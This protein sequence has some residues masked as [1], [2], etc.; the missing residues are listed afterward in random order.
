M[1]LEH[2]EC[3]VFLISEIT[4]DVPARGHGYAMSHAHVILHPTPFS[5][6]GNRAPWS[7]ITSK[8]RLK[9]APTQESFTTC[10][11]SSLGF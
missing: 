5:R 2:E 9:T 8:M 7:K 11:M 10:R 6:R 1:Q 4:L 3:S